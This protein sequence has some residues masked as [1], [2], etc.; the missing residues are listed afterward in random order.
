MY[1]P[2]FRLTRAFMLMQAN[3]VNPIRYAAS[4]LSGSTYYEVNYKYS[5]TICVHPISC[6]TLFFQLNWIGSYFV[7]KFYVTF[8]FP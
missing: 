4:Y 5:F 2:V 3:T 6:D 8:N 1:K 7:Y